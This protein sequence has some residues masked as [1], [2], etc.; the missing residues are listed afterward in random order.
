MSNERKI[1]LLNEFVCRGRVIGK[2]GLSD[3]FPYLT[4]FVKSKRKP[5]YLRI[6]FDSYKIHEI[7]VNQHVWI[8]Y[9]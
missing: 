6:Y 9:T 8:G 7:E 5:N 3:Q 4:I 1:P 2:G